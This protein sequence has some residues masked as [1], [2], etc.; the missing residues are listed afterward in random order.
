LIQPLL[1]EAASREE[2]KVLHGRWL[3][4]RGQPGVAVD[5][6]LAECALGSAA[7]PCT[8]AALHIAQSSTPVLPQFRAAA[9]AYLQPRCVSTA[10][11]AEALQRITTICE[12]HGNLR[13]ALEYQQR[14]VALQATAEAL[15]AA[16]SLAYRVGYFSEALRYAER[17]ER[18]GESELSKS[19]TSLREESLKA[20]LGRGD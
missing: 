8:S 17:A 2:A 12:R 15:L 3:A 4:D 1:R 16:G 13:E 10:S 11:C 9:E 19:V 14:L 7:N 5:Y 6:L 20:M 18:L